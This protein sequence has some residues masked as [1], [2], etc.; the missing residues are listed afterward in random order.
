[1]GGGGEAV[2]FDAHEGERGPAGEGPGAVR[3]K[4]G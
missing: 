1:M 3:W 4:E 2:Y